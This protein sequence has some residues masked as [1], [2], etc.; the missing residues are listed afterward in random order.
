MFVPGPAGSPMRGLRGALARPATP[1]FGPSITATRA[2]LSG[3]PAV[4]DTVPW[5]PA[6]VGA[7]AGPGAGSGAGAGG[8][9]GAGPGAGVVGVGSEPPAASAARLRASTTCTKK[10][11]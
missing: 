1:A 10:P 7:G 4:F 11:T 2:P 8:R 9:A 3:A 5:I 6:V